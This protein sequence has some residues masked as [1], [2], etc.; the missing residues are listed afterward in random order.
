MYFSALYRVKKKLDSATNTGTAVSITAVSTSN[1]TF[2]VAEDLSDRIAGDRL[3]VAGST[4]NDGYYTLASLTGTGPTVL[5]VV[6]TISSAVVDG[7]IQYIDRVKF[8]KVLSAG[9]NVL[10][11]RISGNTLLFKLSDD[12]AGKAW[13]VEKIFIDI[14]TTG[15]TRNKQL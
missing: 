6:G 4:G 12:T 9:R 10:I 5:T 8:V 7:T 3:L 15:R 14:E 13:A 1:K 2:T 11:P